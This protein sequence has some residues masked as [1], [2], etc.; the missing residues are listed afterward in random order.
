MML[1]PSVLGCCC[2]VL[3]AWRQRQGDLCAE[4]IERGLKSA[5][6]HCARLEAMRASAL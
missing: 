1:A 5:N 4:T 3:F 2:D 6:A